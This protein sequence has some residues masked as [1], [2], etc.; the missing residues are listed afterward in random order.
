MGPASQGVP[1]IE[2]TSWARGRQSG[3]V[4]RTHINNLENNWLIDKSRA[5]AHLQSICLQLCHGSIRQA[6]WV[7]QARSAGRSWIALW[8]LWGWEKGGEGTVVTGNFVG[9]TAP[10]HEIQG[11][12]NT[13][14]GNVLRVSASLS[15]GVDGVRAMAGPSGIE[16]E[17][18]AGDSQAWSNDSA[19]R[20]WPANATAQERPPYVNDQIHANKPLL[21]R[22]WVQLHRHCGSVL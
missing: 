9:K 12:A 7:A 8:Q 5:L 10:W 18:E 11:N 1:P 20:N 13:I 15:V 2:A 22:V 3:L 6:A 21:V 16:K 14:R 17:G 19:P 4:K